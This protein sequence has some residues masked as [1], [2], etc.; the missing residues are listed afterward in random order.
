LSAWGFPLAEGRVE[1]SCRII[2]RQDLGFI[3]S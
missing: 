2:T 3:N 1:L